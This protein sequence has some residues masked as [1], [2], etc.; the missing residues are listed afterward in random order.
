MTSIEMSSSEKL[1]HHFEI[2]INKQ[3][4]AHAGQQLVLG[5][6]TFKHQVENIIKIAK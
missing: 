3:K 1:E 4:I 6:N 2:K 5:R